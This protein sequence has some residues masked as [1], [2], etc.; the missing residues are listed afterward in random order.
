MKNKEIRGLSK[1]ELHTRLGELNKELMKENLQRS[2]GSAPVKPGRIK[3]IRKTKARF[4]TF[5]NQK[6]K[7]VAKK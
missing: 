4:L 2:L 5:L 3:Q 7:E 6:E 1:E